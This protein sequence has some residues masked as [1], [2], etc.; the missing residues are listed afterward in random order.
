MKKKL[1][2][3]IVLDVVIG[4]NLLKMV[5]E[6]VNPL[7][8]ALIVLSFLAGMKLMDGFLSDFFRVESSY[9]L[10]KFLPSNKSL[11]SFDEQAAE[12]IEKDEDF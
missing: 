1:L 10:S 3:I 12:M 4:F 5:K 8:V 9:D 6:G 2:A 11:K 7:S